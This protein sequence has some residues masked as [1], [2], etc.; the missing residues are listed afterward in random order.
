MKKMSKNQQLYQTGIATAILGFIAVFAKGFLAS[1]YMNGDYGI[2][3]VFI[4]AIIISMFGLFTKWSAKNHQLTLQKVRDS[5]PL[6]ELELLQYYQKNAIELPGR[7]FRL[8]LRPFITIQKIKVNNPEF[9]HNF[10]LQLFHHSESEPQPA[11]LN[12]EFIL[13]RLLEIASNS[14]IYALGGALKEPSPGRVFMPDEHWKENFELFANTAYSIIV[15]PGYTLSTI[16]EIEWLKANFM[17]GKTIFIMPG[18]I[19]ID[20]SFN[21]KQYWT[22]TTKSLNKIGLELPEYKYEGLIFKLNANGN[23]IRRAPLELN[24]PEKFVE[25]LFLLEEPY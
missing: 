24:N 20:E 19:N 5:F 16:W 9:P 13:A 15:I 10:L 18:H 6:K 12:F 8:F 3:A 25:N 1:E 14:K 21:V 7:D 4:F 23:I 11:H 22:K 17:L 2:V